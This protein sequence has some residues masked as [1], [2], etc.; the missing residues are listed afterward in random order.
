MHGLVRRVALEDPSHRLSRAADLADRVQFH[1][2]S[3]ESLPSIFKVF[4]T[5]EPHECYH[6]AAQSFVSYSFEDEFSTLNTN[7]NGTHFV[8]AA[9]KAVDQ[10]GAHLGGHDGDA[11]HFALQH[12]LHAD[13]GAFGAVAGIGDDDF[14]SVANGHIFERLDQ[15]GE[16]RVR[17]VGDDEAV[18]AA[19]SGTKRAGVCVGVITERLD[20]AAHAFG[21]LRR[22]FV[23]T[24]DGAGYR[25]GR[26]PRPICDGLDVHLPP[27]GVRMRDKAGQS[28]IQTEDNLPRAIQVIVN[29]RRKLLR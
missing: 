13:F 22:H 20:G 6:L 9:M 3:L 25:G 23:G 21:G 14:V 1:A 29:S 11:V 15:F 8:L 12:A 2:G 16:E 7:I 24:I 28:A 26:D 10:V 27:G 4:A 18:H 5:V 17:D 19:A